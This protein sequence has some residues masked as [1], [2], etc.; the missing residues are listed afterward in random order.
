MNADFHPPPTR[1]PR[2]GRYDARQVVTRKGGLASDVFLVI[3]GQSRIS[4]C[5]ADARVAAFHTA[6][7]GALVSAIGA[8]PPL[9]NADF[10][11]VEQRGAVRRPGNKLLRRMSTPGVIADATGA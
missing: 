2:P 4:V 6:N 9:L 3:S 10:G 8:N 7:S 5:A 11:A 1:P